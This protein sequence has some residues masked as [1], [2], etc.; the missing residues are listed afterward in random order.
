[1]LPEDLLNTVPANFRS[2][3]GLWVGISGRARVVVYNTEA[4]T[5]D[6]LPADIWDFTD[7]KWQGKIGWAPTNGSFQVMVTGMRQSWGEA[8]TR[9]WLEGILANDPIAYEN[10][11]AVV[12]AVGAGEIEVGFVNHYYLYRFLQEEG[13]DF[14]ARNYFL[15]GQG[16]G[17]LVMVAGAGMLKQ[18]DNQE[19]A[20]RFLH[21]LLSP[22][23][24]QYFAI[25]TWE[26]PLIDGVVTPRGL[27]PLAEIHGIEM[28][29]TDLADLQG[30]VTLLSEVGAL[31]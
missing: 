2:P 30:T 1:T 19:N 16:P 14:R 13:E 3:E 11:T 27:T 21:F 25:Q 17:S 9:E 24:Q 10:N 26:Y 5:P 4:L 8:K 12:A 7:R 20:L 28:D 22:V 6:E 23:A 31:P 15:P 29:L 18:S